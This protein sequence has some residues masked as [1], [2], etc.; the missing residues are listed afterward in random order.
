MVRSDWADVK[1]YTDF[2]KMLDYDS[3]ITLG[4]L[5]P[6]QLR[7]A[8]PPGAAR[9]RRAVACSA[10]PTCRATSTPSTTSSSTSTCRRATRRSNGLTYYPTKLEFL[11]A[12]RGGRRRVGGYAELTHAIVDLLT[13]GAV[14][15]GW[16]AYGDP[17]QAGF[18]GP[19][20]PR[21]RTAPPARQATDGNLQLR[22]QG[23]RWAASR[24]SAR[25]ACTPSCRS[26]ASCRPSSATRCS[27]RTT[28]GGLGAF[29]FDG[30]NEVFFSGA[31]I[32]VLPILFIQAEA[33]RYFFLQRLSQRRHCKNLTFEQDQNFHSRWTFAVNASLGY[34]F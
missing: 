24:A 2:D 31:R 8:R 4:S 32:M 25:C 9:P 19:A 12:S 14:V 18:V 11:E 7:P 16:T 15:R 21:L 23:R 28:E 10:R 1:V 34:E 20:V 26:A 3:G 30:D 17:A 22:Q 5:L 13:V 27:A 29:Q 33:R 6:L